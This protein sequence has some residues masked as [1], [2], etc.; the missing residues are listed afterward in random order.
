[1]AK[2]VLSQLPL[3]L[4]GCQ[5]EKCNA[6]CEDMRSIALNAAPRNEKTI[7]TVAQSL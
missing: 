5:Y 2:Q 1:M 7:S 3:T 4:K 6:K